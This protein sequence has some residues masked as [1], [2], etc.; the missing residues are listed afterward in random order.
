M[1]K[2]IE[3]TIAKKQFYSECKPNQYQQRVLNALSLSRTSALGWHKEVCDCCGKER[4]SYNN[5]RNRHCPK[6]QSAQQA[7][8]GVFL[9][10][11]NP[12]WNTN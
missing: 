9:Y 8:W 6:C 1:R 12:S 2:R 7:F 11:L 3:P 5:C 10:N 4:I